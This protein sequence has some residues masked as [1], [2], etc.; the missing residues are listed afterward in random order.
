MSEKRFVS[1]PQPPPNAG[2]GRIAFDAVTEGV[3][4]DADE[5]NVEEIPSVTRSL[6]C[7]TEIYAIPACHLPLLRGR[8]YGG[9]F[10]IPFS[11]YFQIA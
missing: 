2:I 10:S 7:F 8:L 4:P 3:A 6:R 1:A 9:I 5:R 11:S